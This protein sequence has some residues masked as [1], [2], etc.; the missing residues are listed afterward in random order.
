VYIFLLISGSVFSKPVFAQTRFS[1]GENTVLLGGNAAWQNVEKRGICEVKNI[2]Q[3]SV[4]ALSSGV[5]NCSSGLDLHVSFDEKDA[6]LFRDSTGNYRVRVS[7]NHAYGEG[8]VDRT[9]ARIGEG[10]AL[11]NNSGPI[12]I[13]PQSRNALFARGN[14]IGDFSIEFW[15]YPLN[16]ENGETVFSWIASGNQLSSAEFSAQR[17]GLQNNSPSRIQ[18]VVSRNRMLW[19][20]TN[21]F[22]P[23]A[24]EFSGLS[25]VIPRKWSH[26]MIRF[27]SVNG[28]IEYL[29]DGV[30]ETI[31][32]ATR[33]GRESSDVFIPQISSDGV[34]KLGEN[35]LG[36]M[37]ELKI[38]K[39]FFGR[40]S[41]QKYPST[42]GR[43][44]SRAIDMGDNQSNVLR[45]NVTGGRTGTRRNL[46]VNEFRDNGLFGFS[47]D[48]QMHFFIRTSNNP[49]LLEN[50]P[51]ISFTPG[52]DISGVEG[53][54]VQIAVDFYPSSDGEVSPYLE[55]L[56][57][58]YLPGEP[59]LPPRNVTAV[60]VDSGVHLR[61]RHSPSASIT[62]YLV[63]YS[64]V[65]GELFG[66]GAVLGPSPIDVGMTD[67]IFIDG[68]RN[69]TLYYFRVAGYDRVTGESFNAGEFSAEV[70]AR[71]LAGLE[72]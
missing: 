22:S 58:V 19:S 50:Y 54:Y 49:W 69:G 13:E 71:P 24:I 26:H 34:F 48:S 18:C 20:F 38:H 25:P 36:L 70:T 14:Y 42:G 8:V 5:S 37:D 39:V 12:I 31:V 28:M 1:Y 10:A 51:W 17:I 68:L 29:V 72:R 47:D 41:T 27:D 62:G 55:K 44:E 30:S 2:R 56:Q 66:E 67:S 65:R 59:V 46:A 63:Y 11:F 45:V 43:I 57:I 23:V 21:F 40:S 60:A 53:R 64:A 16:M 32:Y 7:S 33:T 6:G 3:H 61:W 15:L 9:L 4:L 35:F 52:R